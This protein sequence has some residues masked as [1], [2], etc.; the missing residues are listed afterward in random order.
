M[1]GGDGM[2][3]HRLLL[4]LSKTHEVRVT[5]RREL[6]RY[7]VLELFNPTNSY[8]EV[9]VRREEPLLEVLADFR[10]DVMI[11]AAGIVKQREAATWG[12]PSIEVNALFPHRLAVIAKAVGARMIHFSTDCVFSGRRGQYTESDPPDP[13]DLYGYTKLLGEV[14]EPWCV[15]LR[16]SIVGLELANRRGLVE[17]LLKQT[18]RIQGYRRVIYSG[19]ST[20]EM[21]RVVN[22]LIGDHPSLCGV[23]HV[24]SEPISKHELLV[25]LLQKLGRSDIRV[26]PDDGLV[27]DRTLN[28]KAFA[29]ATGYSPP[30]WNAMLD[31]L[32]WAIQER[33]ATDDS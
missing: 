3:G 23:W 6:D 29:L 9:D 12:I 32:A 2:L 10:P 11:N 13:V 14:N 15:T 30:S 31:E 19:L 33:D 27:C 16:T 25:C 1:L 17:W 18:G 24:A 21:S 5:L 28:A 8:P 22:T 20:Q 26:E 7:A 4:D